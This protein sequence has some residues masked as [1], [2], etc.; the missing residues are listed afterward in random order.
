[1]AQ[2][3]RPSFHTAVGAA[4]EAAAAK[5]AERR[6]ADPFVKAIAEQAA[7]YRAHREAHYANRNGERR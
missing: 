6:E 4:L 1:M 5:A 3:E 7:G 2:G